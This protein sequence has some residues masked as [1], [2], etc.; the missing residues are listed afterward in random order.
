MAS[1][2]AVELSR[3]SADV[4]DQGS[5]IQLH[6]TDLDVRLDSASSDLRQPV[7]F[8]A[9]LR[10]REGG[11]L[12]A[13]GSV[14]PESGAL[15]ADVRVRQLALTPLQPL[16]ARYLKLKIGGGSLSAQGR[17]T[18]GAGQ[19]KGASL[20]YVGGFEIGAVAINEDDGDL[21]AAWK[22][23]GAEKLT[24]SV[25]PNLLDIPEL[26]VVGA[27]A[28]LI[29][30]NDR[31]FNA[32]RL[33]VRPAGPVAAATPAPV[34][35]AKEELF[36]VRIGRVRLQDAKLDFTD[37]SLRP[38]FG[39][40]IY[41][42]NGV[43]SGLSS[44]RD[45]RSRVELDGRVDEFGL[46]RVRGEFNP[47][48]PAHNTDLN[49]VFRNIDMVSAS[50]YTMKFAGYKIAEGKISLDLQY[51]LRSSQLEGANRIVIDK[52][53]LGERVDSP[54]AFKLP[55]ELAIAILKDSDG[56]IDLG[57]PVSGNLDD[58]L[59][60]Y[61]TLIAKA[62]GSVLASIVSAPFRALGRL[63]GGGGGGGGEKLESIDFD[64]GSDRLL[65][66]ERE[67]LK[68]VAQILARREQLKLSVPAQYSEAA[69]GPALKAQAVRL[70]IARRAGIKLQQ[71]DEP[72]PVDT[73]DEAVRVAL[74]AMAAERF[75]GPAD[76][77]Q[78]AAGSEPQGA[79][80]ASFYIGL[81]ERLEQTQP[82]SA[83]DLPRLGEQRSAAILSAL[84]QSGVDAAR[85]DVAAPGKIDT[86]PGKPV[87]L[88]LGLA[89]NR[90]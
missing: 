40:K 52:L 54:D 32:A 74:R 58:P 61:G 55:L 2:D 7:K 78:K 72:G 70:E 16:L 87:P 27:N 68:Q 64:P 45:S 26:R 65:P 22:S 31:S 82:L 86:Q 43:V 46:A 76:K 39:A 81:L 42:L 12:S 50:P 35:A 25:G 28:T 34:T 4:T 24:A 48:A 10:L 85:A 3:F 67:K 80:A 6:V 18:A 59:F 37:L 19:A 89:V 36:P 33:L 69:D 51:K 75:D 38:Q 71:G 79:D 84:S 66:P 53:R 17:L 49:V 62:V 47:F 57:L 41:E 20:R 29:I 44:S 21:F 23:V 11:A 77:L 56:R 8:N 88:K 15:Q 9:G 90:P 73:G 14:V 13:Q 1:V 5:G 60:S 30:E 63:L 83:A